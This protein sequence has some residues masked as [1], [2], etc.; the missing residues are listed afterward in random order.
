MTDVA[1]GQIILA[2]HNNDIFV[3]DA[4]AQV[5]ANFPT[6]TSASYTSLG[7]QCGVAFVAPASGIVMIDWFAELRT[8]TAG[9]VAACTLEV[10]QGS[11]V[12]SGTVV[13]TASDSLP[14]V[15]NDNAN[16]VCSAAWY[17]LT[18]LTPGNNYNVR[19][20]FR[21]DGTRTLTAGRRG[22]RVRTWSA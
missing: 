21:S 11:S 8:S 2:D 10:R 15:R 19:L 17:P 16:D 4:Y 7:T 1:A 6:T 18:G 20:M 14:L 3:A 12:G 9:N 13:V 22:V 5:L